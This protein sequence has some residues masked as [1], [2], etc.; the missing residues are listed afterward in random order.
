MSILELQKRIIK[1]LFPDGTTPE[2]LEDMHRSGDIDLGKMMYNERQK[3][4]EQ[5]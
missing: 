2:D 1:R 4:N 3:E 5:R